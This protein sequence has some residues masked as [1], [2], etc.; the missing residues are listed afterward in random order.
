MLIVEEHGL[1]IG[2][3][4]FSGNHHEAGL[5]EATIN[6]LAYAPKPRNLLGDTAYS[7]KPL[8][9]RVWRRWGIRLTAT[10]K[11]HYVNFFH[12]GRRF[13]RIKRRWKVERTMA[14]LRSYRRIDT[15][16]DV[17]A[18]NYLGFVEL[19]CCMKLLKK[20]L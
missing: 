19:A 5:T 11:R 1:P 2:V 15:R 13:R 3:G 7:S 10:P 6:S 8:T 14:W 9:H 12:D 16:Y 17:K 20:A 18:E 4:V